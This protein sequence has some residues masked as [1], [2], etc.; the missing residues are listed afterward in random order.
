MKYAVLARK[1]LIRRIKRVP[2]GLI[3]VVVHPG[4]LH[5]AGWGVATATEEI[6][7]REFAWE[8]LIPRPLQGVWFLAASFDRIR[9]WHSYKL[10]DFSMRD[11]CIMPAHR[12]RGSKQGETRTLGFTLIE[13]LVATAASI[14]L[15][16]LVSQLF[17]TLSEAVNSD[18]SITQ[19]DSQLR[20]I[21]SALSKD[22]AGYTVPTIRS[23]RSSPYLSPTTPDV[24]NGYFEYIEG[25]NTDT[26]LFEDQ[27]NNY[28]AYIAPAFDKTGNLP[29]P[30]TASDDRIVGDTDDV[31]MF[32]TQ[33]FSEP[34]S[35]KVADREIDSHYAEVAWFCLP[36][37]GTSNPV[38]YTLYRKQL[39]VVGYVNTEP[40][41]SQQQRVPYNGWKTYF[42]SYDVSCR[43]EFV[44]SLDGYYL[45]VNS[46][47][48]LAKRE[49]RMLHD[50]KDVSIAGGK[51][52]RQAL[53]APSAA[54]DVPAYPYYSRVGRSISESVFDASESTRGGEDV[55]ITNVL[56]FDVR[57]IEA[58]CVYKQTE[59][60][61]FV[62]LRPHDPGYWSINAN[63]NHA[64]RTGWGAVDPFYGRTRRSASANQLHT[65]SEY[66]GV[67]EN[68]FLNRTDNNGLVDDLFDTCPGDTHN[69][70]NQ[71]QPHSYLGGLEITLRVF[72]PKT[73]QVRQIT[74]IWIPA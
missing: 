9:A 70:G 59:L 21:R 67:G 69:T 56:A 65:M 20:S 6:Q 50:T 16:G 63:D 23:E 37:P 22:L 18:R 26:L 64:W 38:T 61:G 15:L 29:G 28:T 74:I 46:L 14:V 17:A 11:A 72:D 44:P 12:Q 39:L 73:R 71:L 49:N 43:R 55:M 25:P 33:S 24:A 36:T 66:Y 47:Q 7:P 4:R 42:D 3:A 30:E 13:M 57:A 31:L 51:I 27:A 41:L 32:T 19:L 53:R 62:N 60:L 10:E 52:N 2:K 35:G 68:I 1:R 40:F 5:E 45:I 34:F 48:D 58:T 8:S 54:G